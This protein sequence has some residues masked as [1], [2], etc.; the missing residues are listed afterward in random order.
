MSIANDPLR[1]TASTDRAT[2]FA[3]AAPAPGMGA[4]ASPNYMWTVFFLTW[5]LMM[6]DYLSRQV[7]SSILPALKLTWALS[8][9]QLG[10][11][12]GI[13]ALTVALLAIPLSLVADRWGRVKSITLMAVVW[14]LATIACGMAT[15]YT[16]L[17]VARAIVGFGE[18][19]YGPAGLALLTHAF[20][21]RQRA[22]I[23]GAFQSAAMFGSVLG[24]V[25][26]GVIAASYGWRTAFIVIGAPGLLFA[27]LY[28]FLVRDY[29]TVKLPGRDEAVESTGESAVG[30]PAESLRRRAGRIACHLFRARS[31]NFIYLAFGMQFGVGASVAAWTPTYLNR[32][33]DMPIEKAAMMAAAAVLALGLGLIFGGAVTDRLSRNNPHNRT[34]VPAAFA[35]ISGVVLM[36]AYALPAGPLASGLIFAGALFAVAPCG[37]AMALV[38]EVI[39]PAVRATAGATISLFGNGLGNG[40][41][42][43][44]VGLASDAV[45]LKL[46]LTLAPTL[47]LCGA[48]CILLASRTHDADARIQETYAR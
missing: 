33:F 7:I 42:P 11:L 43:F 47:S 35:A 27:V 15:N 16:Q 14:S 40:V 29:K 9:S 28:A 21:A 12:V 19:A 37:P 1:P 39:H 38:V 32:Y 2:A 36:V 22:T 13:V 44:L 25:L 6:H 10:G 30:A 18:A 41:A 26:G 46:A 48:L 5:A 3:A 17:L 20:P 45:G 4:P 31:A 24:V 23:L 34:R 8:D